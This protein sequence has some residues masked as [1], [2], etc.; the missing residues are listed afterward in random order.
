MSG[1]RRFGRSALALVVPAA[2]LAGVAL[3]PVHAH[4]QAFDD[5]GAPVAATDGADT[6][7]E[8][9][10]AGIAASIARGPDGRDTTPIVSLSIRTDTGTV[11][12]DIVPETV[13]TDAAGASIDPSTVGP[14]TRVRV[15]GTPSS[16]NAIRAATVVRLDP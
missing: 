15:S 9:R 1:V 4:V 10:V 12:V 16:A 7:I 8:G 5:D 6:T 11:T 2:L 13:A 14:G 3:S